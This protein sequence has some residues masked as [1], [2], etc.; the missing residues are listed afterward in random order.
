MRREV[1]EMEGG[2]LLRTYRG[3]GDPDAFAGEIEVPLGTEA[4][5][6]FG[7][8]PWKERPVKQCQ[9]RTSGRIG[10]SNRKEARVFIID[11]VEVHSICRNKLRKAQ[12]FPVKEIFRSRQR[13]SRPSRGKRG[14][15]HDV[16]LERLNE[17]DSGVLASAPA[18]RPKFVVD[19]RLQ[20]DAKALD[21]DWISTFIEVDPRYADARIVAFRDKPREEVETPVGTTSGGWI[22][23]PFDLLGVA[24]L[25][26]HD[27]P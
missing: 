11:L 26:L 8:S 6:F 2:N 5:G 21:A 24:R 13:N 19:F 14:V 27:G 18:A 12:S 23:D 10:D 17:R 4:G 15:T 3:I 9:L 20:R 16:T 22:Q 1:F 25:R 7:A